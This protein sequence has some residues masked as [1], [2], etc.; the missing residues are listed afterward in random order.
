ML[1]PL[2][3]V[4]AG[5]RVSE[6]VECASAPVRVALFGVLL[7]Q[8]LR[9]PLRQSALASGWAQAGGR[10]CAGRGR[11][12]VG[13]EQRTAG[14]AAD[15]AGDAGRGPRLLAEAPLPGLRAAGWGST[16]H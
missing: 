3:T 10:A 7:E 5:A 14:A 4:V 2:L 6:P 1:D 11:P 12:P 16:D 15:Q 13:Q 9:A 8:A